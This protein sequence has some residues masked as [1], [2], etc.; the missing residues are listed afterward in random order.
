V[1]NVW[2][3]AQDQHQRVEDCL[4]RSVEDI[5]VIVWKAQ[6]LWTRISKDATTWDAFVE[7]FDGD[8]GAMGGS[9]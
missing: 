5:V 4:L 1:L 9:D 2:K 6:E 8:A 7:V 3:G